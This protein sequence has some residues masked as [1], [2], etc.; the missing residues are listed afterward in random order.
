ML[1]CIGKTLAGFLRGVPRWVVFAA[2]L[3][4]A[5]YLFGP[6]SIRA[7]LWLPE[8]NRKT[9]PIAGFFLLVSAPA[10]LYF[11]GAEF[12]P[13]YREL[14]RAIKDRHQERRLI[15]QTQH[16]SP[17]EWRILWDFVGDNQRT[18]TMQ[19]DPAANALVASGCLTK[20]PNR[21]PL[22]AGFVHA[23]TVRPWLWKAMKDGRVK[24]PENLSSDFH[25]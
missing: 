2:V 12:A 9:G 4:S 3:S 20:S 15:G 18:L 6:E 10:L 13:I 5:V 25:G 19:D 8:P 23:Y 1:G 24:I 22:K 21:D 17:D 11:V 14:K 7:A 16:F